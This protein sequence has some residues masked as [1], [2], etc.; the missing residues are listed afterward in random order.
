MFRGLASSLQV[1]PH[2]VQRGVA[3][4]ALVV[5]GAACPGSAHA[6]AP[7]CLLEG[8]WSIPLG[9]T[10]IALAPATLEPNCLEPGEWGAVEQTAL[11]PSGIPLIEEAPPSAAVAAP[12]APG[13]T[14]RD[15]TMDGFLHRVMQ[16][17]SGGKLN[18]KNSKSTAL[19]PFQFIDSTFLAIVKRHLAG[20]VTGMSTSQILALRT[21]LAFSRRAVEA[22]TRENAEFLEARGIKVTFPGLRLAHLLGPAGAAQVLNAS[23]DTPLPRIFSGAVL[24]ANPF[25]TRLTVAG[26]VHRAERELGLDTAAVTTSARTTTVQ[27]VALRAEATDSTDA[28]KLSGDTVSRGQR[29]QAKPLKRNRKSSARGSASMNRAA[30]RHAHVAASG[31]H[32]LALASKRKLRLAGS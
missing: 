32:K 4:A 15:M 9:T 7:P 10:N 22:F 14:T 31:R 1:I 3:V 20:E 5:C 21:N 25:M 24:R 19:G 2:K 28:G 16:A 30:S 18:A 11:A 27:R 13:A 17:E 12:A 29:A 6:A 8:E 26:L 23:P